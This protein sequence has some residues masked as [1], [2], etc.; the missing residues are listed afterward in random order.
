M[1]LRRTVAS[2]SD[3]AGDCGESDDRMESATS[4]H[5]PSYPISLSH[6]PPSSLRRLDLVRN[7][8]DLLEAVLATGTP[9]LTVLIHGR[10]AT[11]GG[12]A[13]AR[14]AGGSNG[15]LSMGTGG[16]AVLSIWR[17]GEQGGPAVADILF[18][19]AQPGGRLAQPVTAPFDR[20][21]MGHGSS[22]AIVLALRLSLCSAPHRD[23]WFLCS[24]LGR[25]AMF[26]PALHHGGTSTK[27][28]TTGGT[29]SHRPWCACLW[30]SLVSP[31][32]STHTPPTS[33]C[34]RASGPR[35]TVGTGWR[36]ALVATV[37]LRRWRVIFEL[38]LPRHGRRWGGQIRA[39]R[40]H[41]RLRQPF[42]NRHRGG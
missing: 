11:F 8:L 42:C 14:W 25:S 22:C 36:G 9:T 7:Q 37:L 26:T 29:N 23:L 3:G 28:I 30:P 35:Q 16:H 31:L 27:A 32:P 13:N 5:S 6:P 2:F 33:V 39:E 19:L 38:H 24:G 34:L 1:R 10:P 40:R 15:L 21:G 4:T 41:P 18:G 17:P 12:S 20:H